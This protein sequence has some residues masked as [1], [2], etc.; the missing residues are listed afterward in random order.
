MSHEEPC[1]RTR[2]LLKLVVSAVGRSAVRTRYKEL[3]DVEPGWGLS[4]RQIVDGIVAR[5]REMETCPPLRH[6][7]G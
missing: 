5:E 3:Y 6:A 1:A 4:Q 7:V 2:Q